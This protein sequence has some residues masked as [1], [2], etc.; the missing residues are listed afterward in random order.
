M[1]GVTIPEWDDIVHIKPR[2]KYT[3][4]EQAEFDKKPVHRNWDIIS[5]DGM[6]EFRRRCRVAKQIYSSP[7]PEIVK[8]VGSIMTM[9]DDFEDG[10]TTAAVAG[11][12]LC[13]VAPRMLGRFIPVVGW[14]FLAADALSIFNLFRKIPFSKRG[15][16]KRVYDVASSNPKSRT[17]KAK[18]ASQARGA[19][20]GKTFAKMAAKLP[21]L[22]KFAPLIP[23]MGEMIE[24]AQT[25][26]NLFGVGLC[27]GPIVGMVLDGAF[28]F[29]DRLS[30]FQRR[31]AAA[32]N[33]NGYTKP[34]IYNPILAGCA[35]AIGDEPFERM[36]ASEELIIQNITKPFEYYKWGEYEEGLNEVPIPVPIPK[37]PVTV[38]AIETLGI[39]AYKFTGFPYVDDP[40]ELYPCELHYR[41]WEKTTKHFQDYC[42]RK[43]HDYTG[44]VIGSTGGK[45]CEHMLK[46]YEGRTWEPEITTTDEYR[47]L[48]VCLESGALPPEEATIEDMEPYWAEMISY[49][50]INGRLPRG[51]DLKAIALRHFDHLGDFPRGELTDEAIKLFPE[52]EQFSGAEKL[53][54]KSWGL[55]FE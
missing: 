47:L 55:Q 53:T 9:I 4:A 30:S 52:Y 27:L 14:G 3:K 21:I 41:T 17:M 10:L 39:D 29:Q 51:E 44:Y 20:H 46:F 42:T 12:I 34:L 1:S 15:A 45:I 25:T 32:F 38:A 28:G 5:E 18:A 23:S 11:R 7:Q 6:D 26:D 13:K 40:K 22:K 19:H 33:Q 49:N 43:T 50:D 16:K 2:Y 48:Q 31:T 37:D 24:I 8:K 54:L 36:V 35:D